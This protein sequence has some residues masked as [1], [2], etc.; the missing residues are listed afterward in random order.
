MLDTMRDMLAQNFFLNSSKS[1]PD[2]GKLGDDVDAVTILL[3]HAGDTANLT[4]DTAQALERRS[5]FWLIHA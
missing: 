2:G 4:L 5:L 1:G 3:D